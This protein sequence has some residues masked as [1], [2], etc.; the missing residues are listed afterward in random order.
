MRAT[1]G[2]TVV[3]LGAAMA[4]GTWSMGWWTVPAV[5]AVWGILVGTTRPWLAGLAAA[6]AWGALLAGAPW[7]AF[8]RLAPRLGGIFHLPGWGMVALTLGFAWLLG[9]SAARVGAGFRHA[10]DLH[11]VR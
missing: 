3:L 9:W 5:A 10:R 6:T 8:R 1:S 2:G 7:D 11:N 4:V